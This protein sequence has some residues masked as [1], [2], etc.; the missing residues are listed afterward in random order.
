MPA[1]RQRI[2]PS[3]LSESDQ[4]AKGAAECVSEI[5]EAGG[6]C[7]DANSGTPLK[8]EKTNSSRKKCGNTIRAKQKRHQVEAREH[9]DRKTGRRKQDAEEA[10]ISAGDRTRR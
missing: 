7:K 10:H 4:T 9:E 3:A 5:Q 2:I 8:H 1:L 6:C